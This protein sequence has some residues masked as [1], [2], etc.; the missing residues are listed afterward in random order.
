VNR[1]LHTFPGGLR[2]E[3]YK[4][5]SDRIIADQQPLP[6][7][8]ILPLQQHIG[9]PAEPSVRIGDKVL[10]G[11][12]IARANGYVS[13]PVHASTSGRVVDI[14]DYPVPHP[15]ELTAPCIVIESDGEDKWCEIQ[16]TYEY[17]SVNPEKLQEVIRACGIA[18]LGGAGFPAHVK[19]REGVENAVDTLIINGVECE[20]Y[21]TCDARLIQEKADYVVA[22]TRM[23]RHAVQAQH[24]VIA[25]E[26]DMPASYRALEKLVGDDIELVTV[27]A[28]YPAGGEKQLIRVI[29]GKAVPSGGLPIQIGVV[30][31]NVATAAA[32]Y[33][34]VTRGEPIVSRYVTITGIV[35]RPRNLQVLLGTPVRDCVANCGFDDYD[36]CRIILGGPMMGMHVRNPGIPITK[37]TNCI[38]I[39]R[40]APPAPA[41]PCI[42]CGR[43][44]EVCP[45]SLQPERLYWHARADDFRTAQGYHLFD[46]I[47]CGL[48]AYVCPSRIPLVQYFRYAKTKVAD[49]E[50]RERGAEY[51]LARFLAKN[52]RADRKRAARPEPAP[53]ADT[54][55]MLEKKRAYI[56]AAVERSRR[57]KAAIDPDEPSDD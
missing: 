35:E 9:V 41:L 52:A 8:L 45:V 56:A 27:P 49:A 7:R 23:I 21:I 33:R 31:H 1:S 51:A 54:R 36:N 16:P 43:C 29:T 40:H 15:S 32:V 38:L 10:K 55:T 39:Q 57:K 13:V 14:G 6:E 47:E 48:C 26:D 19:L 44:S 34:A 20:P 42:R 53:P 2:L 17:T 24:C 12:V 4:N 46:C 3:T 11:Q 50:R 25:L 22:G 30:V 28:R 18:G 5:L 37:T